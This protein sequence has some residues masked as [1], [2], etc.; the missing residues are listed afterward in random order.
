[1]VAPDAIHGELYSAENLRVLNTGARRPRL[2]GGGRGGGGR[3][4]GYSVGAT[5]WGNGDPSTATV[6]GPR[7]CRCV[8][9]CR[10]DGRDYRLHA[11]LTR[12]RHRRPYDDRPADLRWLCHARLRASAAAL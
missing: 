1:M 10:V 11:R 12:G 4:G 3:G 6:G 9:R 5:S 8:A 2:G 7:T